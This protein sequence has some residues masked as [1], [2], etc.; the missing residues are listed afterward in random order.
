M[1]A[2]FGIQ[3]HKNHSVSI[4]TNQSFVIIHAINRH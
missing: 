4:N 2:G 1:S 3:I